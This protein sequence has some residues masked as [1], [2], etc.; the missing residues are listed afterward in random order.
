MKDKEGTEREMQKALK[1]GEA[2]EREKQSGMVAPVLAAVQALTEVA[3]VPAAIYASATSIT[4]SSATC[5]VQFI[6]GLT[7]IRAYFFTSNTKDKKQQQDDDEENVMDSFHP[8]S[9]STSCTM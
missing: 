8:T 4:T 2:R 7:T 5:I 3:P 6:C 9:F 1:G